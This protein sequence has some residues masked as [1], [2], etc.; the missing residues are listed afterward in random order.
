MTK[1]I[2]T[3]QERSTEHG[4]RYSE[5]V[6]MEAEI[7]E[8]R[9]A[10]AQTE[11]P[12][13]GGAMRQFEEYLDAN[14]MLVVGSLHHELVAR[15]ALLQSKPEPVNQVLLDALTS[16]KH[17]LE[18]AQIHGNDRLREI[19][20]SQSLATQA[21]AQAQPAKREPLSDEQCRAEFEAWYSSAPDADA[22]P[23]RTYELTDESMSELTKEC[24]WMGWQA[25]HGI[26]KGQ[27]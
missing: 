11:Q 14:R 22:E 19:Q 15:A 23:E 26:T 27:Q 16:I 2:K 17:S 13:Q 21:I 25:A 7:D 20:L 18:Q 4:M 24:I 9:A 10:L 5:V 1:Q 8:L 12:A 3:W 6:Y